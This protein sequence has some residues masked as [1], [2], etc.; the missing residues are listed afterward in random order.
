MVKNRNFHQQN[1]EESWKNMEKTIQ[2]GGKSG[3]KHH[4]NG[5]KQGF[6][7]SKMVKTT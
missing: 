7:P 3:E 4:D 6:K 1:G 5:K 2:N